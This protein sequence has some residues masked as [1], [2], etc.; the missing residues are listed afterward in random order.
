MRRL[1]ELSAAEPPAAALED[2]APIRLVGEELR[3]LA[4]DELTPRLALERIYR[5]R[6]M[7]EADE[8]R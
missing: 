1:A 2:A 3:T 6:S 8:P 5:W 4:V 7:I